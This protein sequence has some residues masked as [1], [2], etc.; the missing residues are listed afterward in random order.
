[1]TLEQYLIALVKQWKLMVTC[2]VVVGVAAYI[3]SKLITPIYQSA[4]IV[5]IVFSSGSNQSEYFSLLAGTQLVQTE[6]TLATSDPVLREVASHYPGLTADALWR[7]V[8]AAPKV[9][10]QLFEIDVR[11]P[12]PTR[13]AALANDV[14][15][16]LIQQQ[17]QI[18]QQATALT[19]NFLVIAQPARPPLKPIQPDNRLNTTI[20]LLA[21]LFLGISLA[22]LFEQLDPHVRTPEALTQLLGW[23]I[24]AT[25]SQAGSK[26]DVINPTGNNAYAETY[27]MLRTNIGFSVIE[28]SLR[29]LLVTSA[30]PGDGKSVI[31]ANLAIFMARA[32]KSTLLVEADLRHPTQHEQFGLPAHTMGFSNA[33]L[34][35]SM[36]T[37]ANAPAYQQPLTP[38]PSPLP[39]SIPDVTGTPSLDP[40]IHAADIPNLGVMLAG[41]LPPNPPELLD[42]KAMPQLLTALGGCGSEVVIFDTPPLLGLSDASILASKVDGTLVVVDITRA[43]KRHL[44]QLKAILEQS[45]VNVLGC[46]VNKQH[47]S[48]DHATYSYHYTAHKQNGRSSHRK[49][50]G[51]HHM[52]VDTLS[53][54]DLSDTDTVKTTSIMYPET[55]SDLNLL[56]GRKSGSRESSW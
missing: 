53:R 21:G 2:I 26:E 38:I 13:A 36:L 52:E 32:G 55:T 11:D 37:T 8:T 35:F 19:N 22:L 24:L 51:V 9:N 42:S 28:K 39:S 14:A 29:T 12:S 18:G 34:A 6:T 46:V 47:R 56:D 49:Q 30:A 40:F 50:E 20:G 33:I 45:G 43:K 27:R 23:P 44:K 48:R 25:I 54:P 41:A 4:A 5:Q 15:N 3:G 31:A 16:T 7:E 1:M 10:T 17:F